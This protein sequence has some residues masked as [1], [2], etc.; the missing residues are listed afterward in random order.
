VT[1]KESFKNSLKWLNE[2][3]QNADSDCVVSLIANKID[4]E[5]KEVTSEEGKKVADNERL[6]FFEVSAKFGMNVEVAFES[7]IAGNLK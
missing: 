1:N 3:R 7:L 6:Q 2:I 4:L 5:N